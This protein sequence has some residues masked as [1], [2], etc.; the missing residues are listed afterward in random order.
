L[1]PIKLYD[2]QHKDEYA[3]NRV[4]E[5]FEWRR[6]SSWRTTRLNCFVGV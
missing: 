1:F 3:L 4:N 6:N 2:K 5:G